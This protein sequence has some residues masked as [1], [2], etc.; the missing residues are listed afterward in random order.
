VSRV[1]QQNALLSEVVDGLYGYNS[2]RV[3]FI[4][5]G[6]EYIIRCN[7]YLDHIYPF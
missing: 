2:S 6:G 7:V 4:E 1:T 3:L 5:Q